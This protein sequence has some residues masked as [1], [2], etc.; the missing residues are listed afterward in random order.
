MSFSRKLPFARRGLS[1]LLAAMLLPSIANAFS[2]FVVRDIQVNG[3]QRVD[4]GT[5]FSYLPVRVGEQFTETQASEAI[6]RL[7]ATGFFSDVRIDTENNVLVVT[8]QER[9]TIASVSF[10]GMREFDAKGITQSLRQVG[11]GE[12]RVFDRSMLERA[13]FEIEQQYLSKGKYGVEINPIIT[14]LPRNRVGVSFEIFEGDRAKIKEIHVIG[15]KA[16]SEGTLKD[17]MELTTS[18]MMTWYTGTD[19]YSREKLEGDVERM[20]SFYLDRGY[21]EYSAEAPQVT[22]SPDR[23]GIFITYTVHEGEPY[24]VRSVKLAGDLL[25]LDDKIAPL[26]KV[27]EGETFSAAE[28]NETAKA[29]SEYLGTLGYAFANVNPNPVLDRETHET[30]LTFYVDP[31]SRVYVRRIQIGGNTRTRDE[32]VRREMRQQEAAWYDGDAV[33]HSRDRIDRLGYFNEVN[34]TSAPVAGSSDQ[35]DINVDVK[36]KPTGLINLGV[37]YGSTD[38]VIL[39]GGISQDNIFGS[40]NTLSLQVNTSETNRAAVLS[41]TNPYWTRDGISKTTSLFYRRTTPYD[42]DYSRGDYRVTALGGG[43]NFGVPI[44]EYDRIF[45]GVSFEH[46]KLSELDPQYTPRAYQDFVDQYGESSNALIFNVGWS[47][48]TRDSALAPHKGGY[49][50]LSADISTLD[51]EYYMLS[52]QQQYYVPLG[53]AYTLAFNGQVDWGRS[54]GSKD[55]PVIKN[56]YGGGIGSVRGY[57]GAS[58]GGRDTLTNDYLGGSRRVVG[59]VQLYLPFPGATRDRSLRWFLFADAGRVDNSDG[60]CPRGIDNYAADPCGWKYSAGIGLSWESPLGPLQLSWGQ[61]LNAKDGD[62][63]QSFQF[64]IGTGF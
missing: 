53:R 29:I 32:V 18:G 42:N 23:L 50:R 30:D 60:G 12:G 64:Q 43:L 19:K 47:K 16:F 52:A 62:D 17:E 27:K 38:G 51:L 63:K 7:Y 36:E 5:V 10:N 55:F 25:G 54:Y 41:H 48:D 40:G 2:P 44:S 57:D 8:V 34:V 22:I 15:N 58:L 9:P 39:S 14:P 56:V 3:I 46:N 20:R 61:A 1:A 31:G 26:V 6:Q 59:N 13:R 11:F 21:L 33:K 37:G 49:T 35:I 24:K 28:T 4:A 45:A